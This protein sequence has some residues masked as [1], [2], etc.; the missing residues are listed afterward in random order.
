VNAG[1]PREN[2]DQLGTMV[3]NKNTP[4]PRPEKA[5]SGFRGRE[6]ALS[7]SSGV[8]CAQKLQGLIDDLILPALVEGFLRRKGAGQIDQ[9][10]K[11]T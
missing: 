3:G 5:P 6:P 4:E 10:E 7:I 9:D 11:K 8:F 2:S 1:N